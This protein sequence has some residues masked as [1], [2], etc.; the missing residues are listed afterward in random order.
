MREKEMIPPLSLIGIKERE[1]SLFYLC[2]F[3]YCT[4]VQT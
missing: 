2:G 1:I 3:F 4:G